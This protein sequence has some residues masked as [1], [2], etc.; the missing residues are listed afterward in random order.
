MSVGIICVTQGRISTENLSFFRGLKSSLYQFH[1]IWLQ[2]PHRRQLTR[3]TER[4]T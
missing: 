2:S 3:N 1:K 4:K